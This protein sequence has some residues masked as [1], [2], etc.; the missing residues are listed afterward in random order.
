MNGQKVSEKILDGTDLYLIAY[1]LIL[2]FSFM[3]ISIDNFS[4][5]TNFSAVVAC[6]NNVGPGLDAV[7]PTCNFGGFS[8]FSK[9]VLIFDM[10]AGRLEILPLLGTLSIST[11]KRR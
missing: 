5:T 9:L 8:I 6:F 10:L 4:I 11:W 7:G 1:S 2:I 3:L